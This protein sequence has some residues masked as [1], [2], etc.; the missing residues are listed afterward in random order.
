MLELTRAFS[1]EQFKALVDSGNVSKVFQSYNILVC[2]EP[3][4]VPSSL[5]EQLEQIT[6]NNT[7]YFVQAQGWLFLLVTG[8]F[9]FVFSHPL[10]FFHAPPLSCPFQTCR[11]GR[12]KT[13]TPV[14]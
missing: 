8:N 14:A 10:L 2:S 5:E 7:S 3:M 1:P 11:N 13:A 6:L 9:I 12:E 4:T